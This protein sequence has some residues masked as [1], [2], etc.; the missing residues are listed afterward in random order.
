[1]CKMQPEQDT[2][3]CPTFIAKLTQSNLELGF[4]KLPDLYASG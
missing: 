1:M 4:F 2:I 3:L